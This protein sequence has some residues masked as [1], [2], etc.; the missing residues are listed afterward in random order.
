MASYIRDKYSA[1]EWQPQPLKG[2][3]IYQLEVYLDWQEYSPNIPKALGLI[4]SS[5]GINYLASGKELLLETSVNT[6]PHAVAFCG[7]G[8][9]RT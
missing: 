7:V 2:Y 1:T 4:S 3:F 6:T 9:N 8:G 5:A